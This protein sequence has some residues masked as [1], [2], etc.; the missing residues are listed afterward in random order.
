MTEIQYIKGDATTPIGEGHKFIVHCCNDQG[1]WGSGFVLALSAKNKEPERSY[2]EWALQ[3]ATH[4][5]ETNTFKLGNY[6]LA[7]FGDKVHVV[8][9]IGQ[10]GVRTVNGVPPVRYEAIEDALR[11]L[12]TAIKLFMIDNKEISVHAPKFGSDLA[13]GDW[14]VIEDIIERTLC[15]SDIP[16]TIYEFEAKV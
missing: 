6:K 13:G 15:A 5:E 12:T 9:M 11:Q 1:G 4:S 16:V 8:N 10:K 2:R 3:L 7:H 14:N